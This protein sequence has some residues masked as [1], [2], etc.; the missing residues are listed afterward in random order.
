MSSKAFIGK[1][2]GFSRAQARHAQGKSACLRQ[3]GAFFNPANYY[4]TSH[5]PDAN[6][7]DVQERIA[8]QFVEHPVA[9]FYGEWVRSDHSTGIEVTTVSST[10]NHQTVSTDD[11][12]G[13][14]EKI[15][16]GR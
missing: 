14:G 7:E 16:L 2:E 9:N 8:T 10:S 4:M 1:I 13:Q 12:L 15:E 5:Q 11:Q 3:R 6:F